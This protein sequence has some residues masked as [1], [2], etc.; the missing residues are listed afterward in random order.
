MCQLLP[1]AALLVQSGDNR[2]PAEPNKLLIEVV[3]DTTEG[4]V[5]NI[6][7]TF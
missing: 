2:L 6:E 4:A 3:Y 7:E 5:I 1:T